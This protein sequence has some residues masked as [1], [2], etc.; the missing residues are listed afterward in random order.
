MFRARQKM[1]CWRGLK[2]QGSDSD[3]QQEH[4]ACQ[5]EGVL[6]ML[7]TFFHCIY[8]CVC[9]CV[10]MQAY[11]CSLIRVDAHRKVIYLFA[12]LY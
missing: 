1:V 5:G 12:K 8:A 7:Y 11:K 3:N 6:L 9:V 4:M 10:H 2:K